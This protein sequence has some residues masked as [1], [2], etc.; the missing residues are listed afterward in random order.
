MGELSVSFHGYSN[1]NNI[2]V[3]CSVQVGWNPAVEPSGPGTLVNERNVI[4][5]KP[6]VW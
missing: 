1:F 6:L 4:N 5:S 2:G 3:V